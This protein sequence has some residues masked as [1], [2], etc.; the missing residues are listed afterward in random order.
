MRLV[1]KATSSSSQHTP[2]ESQTI[3]LD[4]VDEEDDEDYKSYDNNDDG[5][6]LNQD[7]DYIPLPLLCITLLGIEIVTYS[8][9]WPL[10][11]R[12]ISFNH[13][14]HVFIL[15]K[16]IKYHGCVYFVK[17]ERII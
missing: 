11:F 2:H 15:V 3:S 13:V 8:A 5:L 12:Y 1:G 10:S 9:F 7:D 16:A 17:H 4:Q 14:C 6:M